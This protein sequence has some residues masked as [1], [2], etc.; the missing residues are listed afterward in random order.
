VVAAASFPIKPPRL[1]PHLNGDI[2]K[3]VGVM[4]FSGASSG[5]WIFRSPWSFIDA[6]SFVF[7][8]DTDVIF[9][10]CSAAFC[11]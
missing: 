1:H 7:V 10:T 4:W 9:L 3:V 8:S 6:Y 5:W 11:P 2:K